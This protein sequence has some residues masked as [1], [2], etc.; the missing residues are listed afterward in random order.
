M[1]RMYNFFANLGARGWF[2]MEGCSES[3]S[4]KYFLECLRRGLT[5]GD[6]TISFRLKRVSLIYKSKHTFLHLHVDSI[7]ILFIWHGK[8]SICLVYQTLYQA[9]SFGMK[10]KDVDEKT[11]WSVIESKA[12][13]RSVFYK[14][15]I[16]KMW[17][18][19]QFLNFIFQ[20]LAYLS[21]IKLINTRVDI[22]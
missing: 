16:D 2:C 12:V 20:K 14:L 8:I 17:Q 11:S 10:A 19:Q 7:L 13:C 4:M 9:S 15:A 6:V 3:K 5:Q 22:K 21:L 1:P 18:K